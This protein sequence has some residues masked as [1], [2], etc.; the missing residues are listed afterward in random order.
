MN[1]YLCLIIVILFGLTACKLFKT[2][3]EEIPPDF[4]TTIT[5][6][7]DIDPQLRVRSLD[8]IEHTI[9]DFHGKKLFINIWATWCGPC[10]A[11]LPH[12]QSLYDSLRSDTTIAFLF[13][14]DEPDTTVR[15]FISRSTY[16]LP[17]YVCD[18]SK[19]EILD[20]GVYPSTFISNERGEI[21]YI[22]TRSAQW[23]H[24]SVIDFLRKL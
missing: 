2:R 12:L 8:S 10:R 4:P 19:P 22:T 21:V 3:Y 17:I 16:V 24:R 15:S 14:S 5:K 13:I 11:E 9:G 6:L 18:K 23:S 1:K 7:G 20:T